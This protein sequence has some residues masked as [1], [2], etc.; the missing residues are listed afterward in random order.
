MAVS[1]K[2]ISQLSAKPGLKQMVPDYLYIYN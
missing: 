1:R 2:S